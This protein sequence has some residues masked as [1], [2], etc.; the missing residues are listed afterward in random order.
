MHIQNKLKSDVK[1]VNRELLDIEPINKNDKD[2]K[3]IV[4]GREERVS[5][6]ENYGTLDDIGFSSFKDIDGLE[7]QKKIRSE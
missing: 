1:I 5:N 6:P 4:K 7:Y 3:Y 2:Y